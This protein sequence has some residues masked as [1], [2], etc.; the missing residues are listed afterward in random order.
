MP[1]G[2]IKVD[3]AKISPPKRA[4]MKAR[5]MYFV[6]LSSLRASFSFG[7]Y[8]EKYTREWHARRACSRARTYRTLQPKMRRF[9]GRLRYLYHKALIWEEVR[10]V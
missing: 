2:E 1:P 9:S 6:H 10:I 3:D 5:F 8:R 7:G 4:E